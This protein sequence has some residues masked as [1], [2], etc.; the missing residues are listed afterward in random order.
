VWRATKWRR[1]IEFPKRT[2][3]YILTEGISRTP[4]LKRVNRAFLHSG[5]FLFFETECICWKNFG[6]MYWG[7]TYVIIYANVKILCTYNEGKV[8]LLIL[9][10]EIWTIIAFFCFLLEIWVNLIYGFNQSFNLKS[11]STIFF[12]DYRS[13]WYN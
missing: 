9:Y 12:K 13:I 11:K 8:P 5:F 7:V 2:L 4:K 3:I 6:V 10:S 1:L